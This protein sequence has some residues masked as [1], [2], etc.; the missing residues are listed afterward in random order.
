MRRTSAIHNFRLPARFAFGGVLMFAHLAARGQAPPDRAGVEF[1]E[2]HDE[3]RKS[4]AYQPPRDQPLPAVKDADWA[5][6]PIDR[7]VL[8]KLEE[9]G[10]KPA[11]ATDRRTLIRRAY[12]D[13]IGLPPSPAEVD[14]FVADASPDAYAK[15]IDKL[16]ASP[17]YGQRWARHWLDVVRYTDSFDSRVLGGPNDSAFAWRYRDWVVDS[18][19]RDLPF[20]R[21]VQEQ[22]AGDLIP[23]LD[24]K[25]F[26]KDGIVATGVYMIGEWGGGDA[27]KEKLISDI[28]DDQVDVTGRAFM[29]LTVSCARCHDHK[30]DP[31]S[32]KDYY[33]LAGI[34]YSSHIL[35]D[36]GP[37][38]GSPVNVRAPLMS[39][40]ELAQ[41]KADET[42]VAQLD[43]EIESALDAQYT[44]LASAMLPQADKY[45][46]AAWEYEHYKGGAQRP[47]IA[48][49]ARQRGL[50][51]YE[52]TQWVKFIAAPELDLLTQPAPSIGG[53]ASVFGWRNARSA[54]API[55]LINST[56]QAQTINGV[57][58]LTLPGLSVNLH[59]SPSAGVAVSWKSPISGRV[60]ITGRVTDGHAVCG[61]GIAW[62]LA[63]VGGKSAGELASGTVANGGAQ[64]LIDGTGG[65]SLAALDVLAGERVQLTILPKVEYS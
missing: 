5:K 26:N 16:L 42:R 11:P 25:P 18:F 3:A 56:P 60:R 38:G 34:F 65:A 40:A 53:L 48:E 6:T 32:T 31:I 39:E 37:K 33:G 36:M 23:S 14:A 21:F 15:L 24:G 28:V 17:T 43:A 2:N 52:L 12:F 13:L 7:F 61:D 45:L 64:A 8:A 35:S 44:Q 58:G 46:A 1:F 49:F 29:G 9:R 62:S 54:E 51:G 19:N 55:V 20:D 47:P 59:P 57:A 63:K 4:W 10:L 30:F 50:R 41:R 27:D 22:V